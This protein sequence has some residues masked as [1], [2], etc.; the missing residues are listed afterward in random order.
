M[1]KRILIIIALLLMSAGCIETLEKINSRLSYPDMK[2]D[3]NVATIPVESF[4]I[5]IHNNQRIGLNKVNDPEF[6]AITTK[7]Y[8][9]YDIIAIEEIVDISRST[10][11]IL[12]SALAEHTYIISERVGRTSY[13]EQYAYY[14][15]PSTVQLVRSELYPDI[16]DLFER[17][18]FV[19]VFQLIGGEDLII[20]QCH[21]K[22]EDAEKEIKYLEFVVDYYKTRY[23]NETDI[24]LL[25]DFNADCSY[26]VDSG[27]HLKDFK[28]LVPSGYDTTVGTT[29]CAYDRILV[30]QSLMDNVIGSAVV[31]RFDQTYNLSQDEAKKISD[32]YPVYIKLNKEDN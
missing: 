7:L 15:K 26:Y 2:A 22:P 29:N 4:T 25:G 16:Y 13:K 21:I 17:E 32:H 18:P 12:D 19:A 31:D 14:Y 23:P 27:Q 10:P 11:R 20:I 1:T 30:S 8:Q 24:I 6:I 9:K 3:T 5:G 28:W